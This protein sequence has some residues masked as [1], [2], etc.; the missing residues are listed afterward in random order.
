[1]STFFVA[2][3]KHLLTTEQFGAGAE[4]RTRF[5]FKLFMSMRLRYCH[6]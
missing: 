6:Q 4:W 1:V 2:V 5:L 3:L